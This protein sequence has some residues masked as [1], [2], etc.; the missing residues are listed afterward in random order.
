MQNSLYKSGKSKSVVE[1]IIEAVFLICACASTFAVIIITAYMIMSGAPAIAEIGV[2]KFLLGKVWAPTLKDPQFGILPMILSTLYATAGSILL[3]VPV[4]VMGGVFLAF[5]APKKISSVLRASVELLA[6]I[7]SVIYGFL[8]MLLIAPAVAKIFNL[9]IGS[10]LLSATLVLSIMILP[11]IITITETSLDAVP[12]TLSEA[13]LGLGGTE[14]QTIFKVMIPAARSGIM[15]AIVLGIGR[16]IGETMAVIMVAG[17]V[18]NMPAIFQSVRLMTTG[19]V[20][21]MSYAAPFHRSVLFAIG[22][23][24]FVFIMILNIILNLFLKGQ[25]KSFKKKA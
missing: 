9:P 25:I 5:L 2:F 11:T 10:N 4:G 6:G 3:G 22:L 13:S 7:P 8:G 1:K 16:A 19:I 21:E 18:V 23:V 24:L 17:N 15:T 12:E 14:I 20:L